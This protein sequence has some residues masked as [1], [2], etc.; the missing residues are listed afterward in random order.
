MKKLIPKTYNKETS[1]TRNPWSLPDFL[2]WLNE[3]VSEMPHELNQGAVIE[4]TCGH[5]GYDF[6][7]VYSREETEDEARE[8]QEKKK[9]I[10]DIMRSIELAKLAELKKKYEQ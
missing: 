5:G 8:R 6:T 2:K 7:I 10:A 3:Q 9:A 1:P 4:L